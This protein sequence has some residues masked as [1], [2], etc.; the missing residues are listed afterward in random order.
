[1][2]PANKTRKYKPSSLTALAAL[3]KGENVSKERLNAYVREGRITRRQ[4]DKAYAAGILE[5][6]RH[7]QIVPVETMVAAMNSGHIEW[8]AIM[9]AE[10][11]GKRVREKK[12]ATHKA[13]MENMKRNFTMRRFK[14]LQPALRSELSAA[15]S[16]K[17]YKSRLMTNIL[18]LP[19]EQ[20]SKF[21]TFRKNFTKKAERTGKTQEEVMKNAYKM[22]TRTE[23]QAATEKRLSKRER[24]ALKKEKENKK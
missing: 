1:M 6:L 10:D 16:K 5:K 18:S 13:V 8:A 17:N 11:E 15:V 12:H 7:G 4:V 24:N 23:K 2:P 9:D 21:Q 22:A 20:Y 3:E 19:Y 14:N